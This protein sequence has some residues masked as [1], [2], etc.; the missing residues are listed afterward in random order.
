MNTSEEKQNT[1]NVLLSL[2]MMFSS[3]SQASN[4]YQQDW[5]FHHLTESSHQRTL[6]LFNAN[7]SQ[8][9]LFLGTIR[10]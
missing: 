3:L 6:N 4:G 1:N 5:F 2:F 10:V 9:S 8:R 7:E